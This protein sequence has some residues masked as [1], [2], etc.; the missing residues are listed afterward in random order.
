[1]LRKLA[2]VLFVI[3][4]AWAVVGVGGIGSSPWEGGRVL[5]VVFLILAV[6]AFAGHQYRTRSAW[7][8]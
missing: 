3:A 1:M 2:V 6:A 5:F 4:L 8:E 7:D